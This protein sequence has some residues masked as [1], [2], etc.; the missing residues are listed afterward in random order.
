MR[1]L[2]DLMTLFGRPYWTLVPTQNS[3]DPNHL[4]QAGFGESNATRQPGQQSDILDAAFDAH[5]GYKTWNC[6]T[7]HEDN[8]RPLG[9]RN[10]E[11]Y[12]MG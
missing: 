6:Y 12:L 8:G 4:N 3:Q 7:K 1:L 10:K 11:L 2:G 9:E 5:A